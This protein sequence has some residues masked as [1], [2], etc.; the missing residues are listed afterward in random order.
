MK[1]RI[2]GS[3]AS[4]REELE[5]NTEFDKDIENQLISRIAEIE[6]NNGVVAALDKT[7]WVVMW[8]LLI[9]SLIGC[10]YS[11]ATV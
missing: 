8:V 9:A 1:E 4:I 11:F 3:E 6:Q 2:Y 5:G 7:D 10:I